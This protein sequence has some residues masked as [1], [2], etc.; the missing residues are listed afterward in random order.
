MHPGCGTPISN[1]GTPISNIGTPISNNRKHTFGGVN[2]LCICLHARAV[3][4]G[5]SDQC[6]WALCWVLSFVCW[7]L[8]FSLCLLTP[9]AT[10]KIYIGD[11]V[12]T[13][14]WLHPSCRQSNR[15]CLC[16]GGPTVAW[17]FEVHKECETV[18]IMYKTMNGQVTCQCKPYC[19][20]TQAQKLQLQWAH[21][22]SPQLKCI[23]TCTRSYWPSELQMIVNL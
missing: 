18:C 7:V 8:L 5:N 12:T 9:S 10:S 2:V 4:V 1:T 16:P 14:S 23:C 22:P 21:I 13:I 15:K 3:T 6:C 17:K 19:R 20:S 11:G